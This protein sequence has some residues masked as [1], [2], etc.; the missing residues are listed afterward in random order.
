MIRTDEPGARDPAH[1]LTRQ[2]VDDGSMTTECVSGLKAF[3]ALEGRW[4]ALEARASNRNPFLSWEWVSEWA[5]TFCGEVLVTVSVS[6]GD[7]AVAL[8]PFVGGRA[9]PVPGLRARHLQL[10]GP[11]WAWNILEMGTMLVDPAH[12]SRGFLRAVEHLLQLAEWDWM[13]VAA[14]GDSVRGWRRAL[15][16]SGL[17]FRANVQHSTLVPVMALDDEWDH[18]RRRLR[19]NIKQSVRHAYNSPRA[20]GIEYRYREHHSADGLDPVLEDFFRLHAARANART[21]RPH[22]DFFADPAAREFFRRAARRLADAGLLSVSICECRGR[23]VATRVNIETNGSRYLYYSGFD[24][25]FARYSVMTYTTTEAIK[26]AMT[27]GLQEVNFSPG[28]DQA[29]SRWDVRLE[30][31][32][33]WSIVRDTPAARARHALYRYLREGM[34]RQ[35]TFQESVR[36]SLSRR[37]AVPGAPRF[38]PS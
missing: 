25:E 14:F 23:T 20:G 1:Q 21:M 36:R 15:D 29:K 33:R 6:L 37:T 12:A 22:A 10:F 28:V 35:R 2:L 19:R 9:L 31:L 4:R 3:L 30:P 8:A 13:E 27:R 34:K 16:L 11:R 17:G 5:K 18:L 24:P 26:S 7:E 38:R 32:E